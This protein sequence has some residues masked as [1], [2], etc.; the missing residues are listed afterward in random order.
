MAPVCGVLSECGVTDRTS[1]ATAPYAAAESAPRAAVDH[2]IAVRVERRLRRVEGM[3]EEHDLPLRL[4]RVRVQVR[5]VVHH[6]HRRCDPARRRPDAAAESEHVQ[7]CAMRCE[8]RRR[9]ATA[10]PVRNHHRLRVHVV[11]PVLLHLR[12]DPVDRALEAR[13]SRR[14]DCRR[15][16]RAPRDDSTRRCP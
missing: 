2:G 7:R 10:H 1:A 5:E 4:R 8:E 13:A 6:E 9:F 11:E 3:I 16:R 12:H 15:C 14:G